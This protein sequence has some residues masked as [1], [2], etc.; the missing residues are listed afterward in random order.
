MIYHLKREAAFPS[1]SVGIYRTAGC[2][3]KE[4][5][6]AKLLTINHLADWVTLS[7]NRPVV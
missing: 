4:D 7:A 3:V 1:E 5:R 2:H 6:K